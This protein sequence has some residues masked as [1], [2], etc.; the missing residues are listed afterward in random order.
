MTGKKERRE[1]D[2]DRHREFD[3]RGI[4]FDTILANAMRCRSARG[5]IKAFAQRTHCPLIIA[6]YYRTRDYIA[7]ITDGS[8]F[9]GTNSGQRRSFVSFHR[10]RRRFRALPFLR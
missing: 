2:L 10:R 6:T 8:R 1:I 4:T 9:E 7:R 5:G 3:S